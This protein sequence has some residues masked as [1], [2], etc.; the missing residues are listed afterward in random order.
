MA[1]VKVWVELLI[2]LAAG[3]TATAMNLSMLCFVLDFPLPYLVPSTVDYTS[4]QDKA[5]HVIISSPLLNNLLLLGGFGLQHS[6]MVRGP[7]NSVMRLFLSKTNS[8]V[9]Y[10]ALTSLYLRLVF[11][12]WIPMPYS[13]WNV[14][15][16]E[17]K[18]LIYAVGLLSWSF[19]AISLLTL[20]PWGLLGIKDHFYKITGREKGPIEFVSTGVYGLMRHPT[21]SF[22]MLAFF[23]TPKMT[24]GHLLFSIVLSIYIIVAVALFE[25]PDLARNI[26]PK[27]VEYM[28]T[29]DRK[30]VV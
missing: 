16:R 13:L 21:Y 1:G 9:F 24:A 14:Q 4:G 18:M 5:F 28:K 8:R 26:G 20:D 12:L 10:V 29:T 11:L 25:E 2:G 15:Q 27:Y 23:I 19:V 6:G 7:V 30:S 3:L 17:L 22:L